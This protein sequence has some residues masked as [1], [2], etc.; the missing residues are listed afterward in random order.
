MLIFFHI[1]SEVPRESRD[2][3]KWYID[4][5]L[6]HFEFHTEKI[7]PLSILFQILRWEKLVVG[8]MP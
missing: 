4:I 3:V 6:G 2:E 8:G 1:V 7:I 5:A